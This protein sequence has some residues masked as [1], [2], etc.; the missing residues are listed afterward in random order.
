[1]SVQQEPPDTKFGPLFWLCAGTGGAVMLFGVWG[2]LSR[3]GAT[4]PVWLATYLVGAAIVHDGI[5][6]P[7]ACATGVVLRRR[8]RGPLRASV[9]CC[10]IVSG[11]LVLFSIPLVAGFGRQPDNP[12]LLPGNYTAGLAI[13]LVVASASIGVVFGLARRRARSEA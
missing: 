9:Q 11:V 4:R 8:V 1:M 6:A 13:A 12:S 3:A 5:V 2:A 10:L 7:V